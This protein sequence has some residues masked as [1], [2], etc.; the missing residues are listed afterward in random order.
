MSQIKVP[1]LTHP[2][3]TSTYTPFERINVDTV[4]PLPKDDYGNEFVVVI[5]DTFTRFV[6]LYASPSTESKYAARAIL[7]YVGL[8]GCPS[9]I[10]SDNGSQYVNDLITELVRLMDSEHV[11]TLRYS[12]EENAIVERANKEV[13]R[14]LRNLLF[15]RE[16]KQIWSDVLPLVQRI[17][18]AEPIEHLGVSPA[19]LVFGNAV[20]LDR[21]IFLPNLPQNEEDRDAEL[22]AWSARMLKAQARVLELA[23]QN[24]LRKDEIHL[25]ERV[26]LT[27]T[28]FPVGSY[29]L[30]NYFDGAMGKKPP[31][32]F[33]P[34]LKG[35]YRVANSSGDTYTLQN[36]V[37]DKMEDYHVTLLRPFHFDPEHVDPKDV[38]RRDTE[39]YYVERILEHRGDVKRLRTLEFLVKWEGYDDSWNSWEPWKNLRLTEAL[40]RYLIDNGL[41]RL[42]PREV[43]GDYQG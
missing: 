7:Q 19:Q 1:I 34:R 42:I 22:S 39:E 31:T 32:K 33:H 9:Q 37:S 14:H 41:R 10:L 29:V 5:R 20:D 28:S 26:N 3:V 25:A 13:L 4:G 16:L 17:M 43:Q 24:Q 15:D 23:R 18:N 11:L 35:P 40:H 21:G 12:K 2:F 38:A 8:L 27:P 6:G 30:V 36:L